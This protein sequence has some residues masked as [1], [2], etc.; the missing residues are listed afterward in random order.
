MSAANE[1]E[2]SSKSAKILY[3]PIGMISSVVGGLSQCAIHPALET[4]SAR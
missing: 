2:S 3:R 1:N 4:R